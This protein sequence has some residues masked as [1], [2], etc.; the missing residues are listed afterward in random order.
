MGGV[1]ALVRVRREIASLFH[2]LPLD[3]MRRWQLATQKRVLARTGPCWHPEPRPP[4]S[5]AG[6]NNFLRFVRRLVD[7]MLL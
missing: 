3:T 1:R 5:R 7:G 6:K 4:A 2:L